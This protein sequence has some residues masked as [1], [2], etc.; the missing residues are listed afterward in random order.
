MPHKL[1]I[2]QHI[3][4]ITLPYFAF[5]AT[6]LVLPFKLIMC[7]GLQSVPVTSTYLRGSNEI[8]HQLNEDQKGLR[9][10]TL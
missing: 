6:L 5:N 4:V 3:F 10:K 8:T 2:L 1:E 7:T 9:E